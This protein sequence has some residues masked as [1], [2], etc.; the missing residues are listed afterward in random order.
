[1]YFIAKWSRDVLLSSEGGLG[2]YIDCR[3]DKHHNN[4]MTG[5]NF[6]WHNKLFNFLIYTKKKVATHG[7]HVAF[8]N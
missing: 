2:T 6:A 1:M 7:K 8:I 3:T 5:S 4:I